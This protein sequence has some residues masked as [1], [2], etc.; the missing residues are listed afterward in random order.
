M[1]FTPSSN[2][3]YSKDYLA[4]INTTAKNLAGIP[5]SATYKWKFTTAAYAFNFGKVLQKFVAS[6][7]GNVYAANPLC[8]ST[9]APNGC[10]VQAKEICNQ[11]YTTNGTSNKSCYW[12]ATQNTCVDYMACDLPTTNHQPTALIANPGV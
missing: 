10:I 12:L 9:V 3:A 7:F 4:S 1:T 11:S 6:I 2:L 8:P 5:I